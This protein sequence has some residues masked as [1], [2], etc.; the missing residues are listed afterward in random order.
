M[1]FKILGRSG[2]N[3]TTAGSSADNLSA[4]SRKI[5]N[6]TDPTTAQDA[7][8]KAYVDLTAGTATSA[9]DGTFTI[10]NTGDNTKQIA[11]DASGVATG[12]TRTII[13]PN[14]NVSLG[15]IATAIQSSEKGAA[16][17]VA[18]LDAGGKIPVAQL[19]NS[20]MEYQGNW[21]ASTNTPT[22]ADGTGSAG[23][24]YR[25][26]VAGTQDLGSGAETYAVGD[27]AVYNGTIW[28]KSLNSNAVMSVN[29]FTGTVVLDTD[30]IAEGANQYFTEARVRATV[31]T[32][33][34]ATNSA[35]TAADS[36]LVGFNKAQGQINARAVS[37]TLAATT[38]G[39]GA[40]L[41][42]IEDAG[43]YYTG[44]TVE[45][46]LQELG[47]SRATDE[48][49][50]ATLQGQAGKLYDTGVAGEGFATNQLW[51]VRRAKSGETAGRYYKATAD[52]FANAR[53]VG[54]IITAGTALSAADPCTVY[55]LGQGSLGSSDT[56][57]SI[58]DI[59]TPVF[60][61]QSTAGKWTIAPSETAGAI[62][63]P[64]GYIA[65]TT[66]LEF[67]PDMAV[68]A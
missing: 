65:N 41:I 54:F 11:F 20:V 47:A 44:T 48:A 39:A 49:N 38:T 26:N 36:V 42:G 37:A 58:G 17:G 55:K 56:P 45:A 30:D 51:L 4:E 61:H 57:F 28:Q 62:L 63:K 66:V 31:L 67:Q 35:I 27:W 18:T 14:T 3:L 33:F 2:V 32:G 8:T 1:A 6:L 15:L 9:L 34:S 16:L 25:A 21:N 53:V 23:D 52:S 19:P 43:T 60:L 5:I 68:Q 13:M 24:V 12:T 7:A 50:I 59:N 22:L 10:K 46:G 29:G 64:V 40:S